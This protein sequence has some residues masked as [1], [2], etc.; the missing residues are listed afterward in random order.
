MLLRSVNL[1]SDRPSDVFT[2]QG[3]NIQ[4][5]FYSAEIHEG[6][7][8]DSSHRLARILF[9]ILLRERNMHSYRKF[10]RRAVGPAERKRD[11]VLN[12]TMS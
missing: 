9:S 8:G 12:V 7:Y 10:V 5:I 4:P 6:Y 11:H 3:Q 1:D 2:H